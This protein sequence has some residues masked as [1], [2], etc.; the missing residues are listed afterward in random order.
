MWR[1]TRAAASVAAGCGHGAAGEGRQS[2]GDQIGVQRLAEVVALHLVA[3]MF[4]QER[5]L[6]FGLD[7]FGD[8][9]Q[10]EAFFRG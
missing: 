7:A 6:R 10:I 2:V 9:F 3:V 5:H 8:D 4:A 1:K